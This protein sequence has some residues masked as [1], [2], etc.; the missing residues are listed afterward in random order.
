MK[1]LIVFLLLF[2]SL[3]QADCDWTQIKDNGNGTYT[4]PLSLHLCVGQLVQANKDL[5]AAIQLKDLAIQTSDQRT[6]LWS[7]VAGDEQDRI[8]KIDDSRKTSEYVAFGLGVA[9]TF[10]S[11]YAAGSILRH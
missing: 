1:G 4:Y 3:A 2:S 10:L 8:S 6:A 7:K 11:A 5:T 9:L